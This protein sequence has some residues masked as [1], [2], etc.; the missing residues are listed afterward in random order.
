MGEYEFKN[1][2]TNKKSKAP[3]EYRPYK[4]KYNNFEDM[5]N[6]FLKES[7]DKQKYV[8]TEFVKERKN[9]VNKNKDKDNR[10]E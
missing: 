7:N 5:L 4:K 6:E 9:K 10:E 2:N 8:K 3:M 1:K